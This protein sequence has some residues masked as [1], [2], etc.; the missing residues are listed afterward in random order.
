MRYFLFLFLFII[1]LQAQDKKAFSLVEPFNK[2]VFEESFASVVVKV[3]KKYEKNI[4][5]IQNHTSNKK[6]TFN[7]HNKRDTY[8]QTVPLNAGNNKVTISLYNQQSKLIKQQTLNLFF[9]V[10]VFKD[11]V[12]I[13]KGYKKVFFHTSKNENS[14]KRCHDMGIDK[15]NSSKSLSN[16]S[17]SGKNIVDMKSIANVKILEDTKQSKCYT[18]HNQLLSRSNSHAPSINFA[19]IECHDGSTNKFNKDEK[20]KSRFL[21]PDPIDTQCKNCHWK[22]ES[23]WYKSESKHGPVMTGRCT[24]CHNPHSSNN[25]FFLHK[26][27][28]KLCTTCHDEKAK[29]KH[30]LTSFVFGR[31]KGAHPTQG[32][33]DP[34]RPGRELVC[35]GCHNPHGSDGIYLLR[36][37]GKKTY[38]VCKR[39]HEK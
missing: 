8:C 2:A 35:S 30:V 38:S 19:C 37:T 1:S 33:P 22:V 36:T 7:I 21:A 14:C 4:L 39:C 23:K 20:N 34:A 10:E 26:P 6:N 31:N 18:C 12:T 11:G 5:V 13:P 27:I 28:W 16:I 3:N 32:R 17:L 9:N 29:G 15:P 25:E 24:K